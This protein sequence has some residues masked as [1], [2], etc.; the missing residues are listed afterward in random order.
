MSSDNFA[1]LLREMAQTQFYGGAA[2]FSVTP[3]DLQT[4]RRLNEPY[5]AAGQ[6]SLPA[7]EDDDD[8]DF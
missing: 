1:K 7:P 3:C 4:V 5:R 8:A 6:Y 2:I